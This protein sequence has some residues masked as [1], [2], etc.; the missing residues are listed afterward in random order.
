MGRLFAELDN[1][2]TPLGDISLRRRLIPALSDEP[3]FEVKL[4]EE[5]LMSSLF[6]EAELALADLGLAALEGDPLVVAVGGLG[7]GY[8]ARAALADQRVGE[9]LVI[10]ALAPVIDWHRR[11]LVPVGAELSRDARCR[12]VQASF[13]DLAVSGRLDPEQPGR[14]FDAILLDIDHS[15]NDHLNDTNAGFY[16]P[17]SLRQMASQLRP[18]GVFALWS[19]DPPEQSFTAL[20]QG[21]F[22]RAEA[23]A[24]TFFNP[25]QNREAVNTVYVAIAA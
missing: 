23:H 13:F 11:E 5:F 20:L 24:V 12:F 18:G 25:L 21:V 19:N 9:L 7:L 2:P 14:L 15:P 22:A 10:E 1:Q 17:D 16:T 4:G 3:I 6:V 8:T